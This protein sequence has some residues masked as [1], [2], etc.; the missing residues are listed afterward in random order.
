MRKVSTC[1]APCGR[2]PARAA[3]GVVRIRHQLGR[4]ADADAGGRIDHHAPAVSRPRGASAAARASARCSSVSTPVTLALLRFWNLLIGGFQR[5]LALAGRRIVAGPDTAPTGSS[6]APRAECRRRMRGSARL[7]RQSSVLALVFRFAAARTLA[8]WRGL[9]RAASWRSD[10]RLHLARGGCGL[11]GGGA[12]LRRRA[13]AWPASRRAC[14]AARSARLSARSMVV[15]RAGLGRAGFTGPGLATPWAS[16]GAAPSSSA[17]IT[18]EQ[19]HASPLT[20]PNRDF[21]QP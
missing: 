5:V 11:A 18:Q 6:A 19:P 7:R 1:T 3:R 16:A 2:R 12:A 9:R 17:S 21:R 4:Q 10:L 13:A 20:R 15:V 8:R 14:L